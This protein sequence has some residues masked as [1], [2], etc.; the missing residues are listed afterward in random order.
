[1]R[2]EIPP[3][4]RPRRQPETH[5]D[6]RPDAYPETR[7]A[8]ATLA[9]IDSVAAL[10]NALWPEASLDELFEES[11]NQILDQ[12]AHGAVFL[13]FSGRGAVAIGMAE[14]ALRLDHVNGC[15]TSPVAF[16]EGI[17]VAPAHRRHGI[18]RALVETA[19]AWG[20]T[21][22]CTEFASDTHLNNAASRR[23]HSAL[24]FEETERV[25]Y[26]RKP[27]AEEPAA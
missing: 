16:L 6:L 15:E 25:V 27:L 9:D 10:R 22:G 5:A 17:Y 2:P 12:D 11:R 8:Q 26:F 21:H 7:I 3:P 13:A 14:V 1:M 4:R 20:R 19:Q 24:G 18:A 23:F